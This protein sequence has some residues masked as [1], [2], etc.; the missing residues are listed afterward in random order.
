MRWTSLVTGTVVA[1]VQAHILLAFTL[2]AINV[3]RSQ[4]QASDQARAIKPVCRDKYDRQCVLGLEF[5][6]RGC[7]VGRD[8]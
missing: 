6:V 2:I 3:P 1:A 4:V 5:A 7:S 8:Y